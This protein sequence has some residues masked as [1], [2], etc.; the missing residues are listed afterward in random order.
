VRPGTQLLFRSIEYCSE[1]ISRSSA[2][3]ADRLRAVGLLINLAEAVIYLETGS[4]SKKQAKETSAR[5]ADG[6]AEHIALISKSLSL[7]DL[8]KLRLHHSILKLAL[9]EI[10]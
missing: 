2:P 5:L 10:L 4:G 3:E 8:K 1:I 6:I 7:D 9:K